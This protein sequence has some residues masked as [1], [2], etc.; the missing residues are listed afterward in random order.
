MYIKCTAEGALFV[1]ARSDSAIDDFGDFA[2]SDRL[3]RLLV[4]SIDSAEEADAPLVLF[5]I[6]F[7][8]CGGV[9]LGA[10]VHQS[11]AD[12]LA[13][14]HFI[15]S[16]AII[17]RGEGVLT[18]PILD[19]TLLR[20]RSPL[21]VTS[22]HIEYSQSL[23]GSPARPTF[24][25]SIIKLSKK[26]LSLLKTPSQGEKPLSTFKAIAAHIWRCACKARGLDLSR[27]TRF[28][29]TADARTR[30]HPSLP[31]NFLGNAIFL[32]SAISSV[33][34]V[35]S[36]PIELA[37]GKIDAATARLDDG[38]VRSLVDYL[39][40]RVGEVGL[41][42]GSWVMAETDMWLISWQGLP[43]H[44]ADF[45]WGK[46]VYMGRASLHFAG[47]VYVMPR[48]P[49]EEGD[50]GLLLAV[51]M[52]PENMQR[53]KEVFDEELRRIASAHL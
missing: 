35:V 39:D 49:V 40:Q 48:S 21:V 26:Q 23:A 53:F 7:F 19:R 15:N 31:A 34:E 36:G 47:Q 14:L 2:P 24:T 30:L 1:V 25:T 11:A 50:G 9:C 12:G 8:S 20:A 3:R 43:I 45:G 41:R 5:Q 29:F 51:A 22:E 32:A 38:Y 17:T 27:P 13:A 44:E 4:P 10:A 16:W 37:A 28:Y 18:A 6:T 52:E 46:P 33:G 42:R